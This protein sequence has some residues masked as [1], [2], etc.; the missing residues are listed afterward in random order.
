MR[1]IVPATEAAGRRFEKAFDMPARPHMTHLCGPATCSMPG[2]STT[3]TADR[4][5][6]RRLVQSRPP[7]GGI[8]RMAGEP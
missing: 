7:D 5:L 8:L 3:M 2:L 1:G 6:G 4:S